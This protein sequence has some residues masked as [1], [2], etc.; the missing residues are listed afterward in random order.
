M[1]KTCNNEIENSKHLIFECRNVQFIWKSVSNYMGFN[2][3]WKHI[4]V[5]FFSV[6]SETTVVFN[7]LL[8]F[9][10]LKIYKYKMFCRLENKEETSQALLYNLKSCISQY[11]ETLSAT[12]NTKHSSFFKKLLLKLESS[13]FTV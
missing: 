1:C 11:S 3:Q 5:G 2:I 8:S 12:Q 10:A 6:R 7:L 13:D 4:V 9:V